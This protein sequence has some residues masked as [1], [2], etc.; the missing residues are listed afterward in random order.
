MAALNLSRILFRLLGAAVLAVALVGGWLWQELQL[1]LSRPLELPEEGYTLVIDPGTS[2]RKLMEELAGEGVIDDPRLLLL[3]ARWKGLG[4]QIRAGEYHLEPGLTV[5]GLLGLLTAGRVVQHSLTLVEGWT[6]R[7]VRR[8]I[9]QTDTLRQT[10]RGLD[11][12]A[13]MAALG[14]P[15]EHPEGR[16]FPD[17]YH[18]P[19][20]T[21]DRDFLLRAYR[22][23]E[24][25]LAE[26]WAARAEGLPYDTPYEALVMA[27]IIEKETALPG[28]R[29]LI[30]GV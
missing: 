10:L 15:D 21:T 3:W 5:P 18:F 17:T 2:L 29:A 27:S 8:A 16:F 28:E 26:E 14:H 19:A 23:M 22:T 11:D 6:F 24:R 7:D 4:R 1:E 20:G 30:A 9:E 12:G 13:V 25:V